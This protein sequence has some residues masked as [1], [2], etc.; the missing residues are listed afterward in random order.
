M[1]W[2]LKGFTSRRITLSYMFDSAK[3]GRVRGV[4]FRRRCGVCIIRELFGWG[5]RGGGKV[6]G[7]L[8]LDPD[9][10]CT[11]FGGVYVS[12]REYVEHYSSWADSLGWRV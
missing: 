10:G 3:Q 2:G 6:D 5:G 9:K 12:L 8:E 11:F 4:L 1:E 7:L